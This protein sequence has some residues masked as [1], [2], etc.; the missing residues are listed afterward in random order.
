MR[1]MFSHRILHAAVTGFGAAVVLIMVSSPV[2]GSAVARTFTGGGSG[3]MPDVAGQ[4]AMWDAE[5]SWSAFVP[6]FFD[7]G[8]SGPTPETAIQ[9]A[10]WDAEITASG[11]GLFTCELVGEPAVF[12]QPPGSPRSFSAQV[13]LQCTP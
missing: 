9:A 4:A 3:P 6:E 2:A 11:Y 12:P 7:G 5:T 13:R 8:G 1:E 10:I